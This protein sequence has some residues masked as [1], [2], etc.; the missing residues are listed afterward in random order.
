MATVPG[1][2]P[3]KP[4]PIPSAPGE[5]PTYEPFEEPGIGD[6]GWGGSE[7]DWMPTPYVPEREEEETALP[8][9]V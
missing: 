6:P 9:G 7:P 5:E 1:P 2:D 4:L 3:D 8:L